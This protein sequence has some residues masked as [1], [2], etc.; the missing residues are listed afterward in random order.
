MA[1][2]TIKVSLNFD[3]TSMNCRGGKIRAEIRVQGETDA[4]G[5][6]NE[7]TVYLKDDYLPPDILWDSGPLHEAPS[8]VLDRKFGVDL[9]CNDKCHVVGPAGSSKERVAEIYA[10]VISKGRESQTGEFKISCRR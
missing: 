10:H 5:D 4:G 6:G 2:K 3:A 7:F 9:W 8:S 1:W